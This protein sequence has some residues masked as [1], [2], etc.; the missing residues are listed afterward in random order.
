M[1]NYKMEFK[2][3]NIGLKIFSIVFIVL[4]AGCSMITQ[5]FVKPI[6]SM[7]PVVHTPLLEQHVRFLSETVHPRNYSELDNLNAAADYIAKHFKQ[8]NLTVE[9]Q[10]F[11]IDGN[12]Y[13]NII[14]SLGPKEGEVLI[15][16]AHYDSFH[17]TPGA[18]DNASGVAGLLELARLLSENPPSY[19]VQLIAYSLEEP[20]AFATQ[21]MGSSVHARS[22]SDSKQKIKLM[23]A[24]EMIGYFSDEK[25]SQQFPLKLLSKLYPDQGNFISVIGRLSDSAETRQVKA[26]MLGATDL[27]VHSLNA[28][29]ALNVIDFS[30]HRN[31]WDADIKAVMVTDT[32]FFR[33]HN[34][35]QLT[36]TA[37]T[38][39]YQRMAKVVQG[40]YAVVQNYDKN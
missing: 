21:A 12:A 2:K 38:L 18:D 31:Y 1:A 23:I 36:D 16:G 8:L 15:V 27:P 30:D 34:Y 19:P 39:D 3:K 32:A 17:D 24:L 10:V 11:D 13:R 35:H 22:L 4:V 25:S 6:K 26:L 5:P 7:P 33:N 37:S 40:V 29:R 9:E 14:A 28:P 20:P